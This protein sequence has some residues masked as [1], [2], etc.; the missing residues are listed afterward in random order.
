[1]TALT[2]SSIA[3]PSMEIK[4]LT[5]SSQLLDDLGIR[6]SDITQSNGVIWVEGPS[7]R[8]YIKHWLRFYCKEKNLPEPK[9]NVDY[10]FVLYG[11]SILKHWSPTQ[12]NDFITMIKVNRNMYLVMDKDLDFTISQGKFIPVNAAST[13]ARVQLDVEAILPQ[14]DRLWITD[15]YTMESYIEPAFRS[16]YFYSEE[17]RLKLKKDVKKVHAAEV[18]IKSH[19][20]YRACLGKHHQLRS[21]IEE[22]L[23]VI[24]S[25]NED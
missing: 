21:H 4:N 9:E 12:V 24:K 23:E 16:R 10:S 15:G 5:S 22:I 17:G 2:V 6:A 20:N 8:L 7:D 13:K 18:Y 3:A 11:G 25:W 14:K 1:M 19:Q